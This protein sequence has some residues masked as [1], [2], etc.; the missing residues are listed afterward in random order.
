MARTRFCA[1]IDYTRTPSLLFIMG[2][3]RQRSPQQCLHRVHIDNNDDYTVSG[4]QKQH[5]QANLQNN[6]TKP[7]DF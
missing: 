6:F 4:S 5:G 2:I 1:V 3:Q 7:K